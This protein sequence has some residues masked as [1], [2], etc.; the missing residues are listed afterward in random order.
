MLCAPIHLGR[1]VKRLPPTPNFHRLKFKL[2]RFQF[3][4]R[5]RNPEYE[6]VKSALTDFDLS[7]SGVHAPVDVSWCAYENSL[8][9]T[10]IGRCVDPWLASDW[11]TGAEQDWVYGDYGD[12][13]NY[14]DL[15]KYVRIN[16]RLTENGFQNDVQ[17]LQPDF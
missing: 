1:L 15:V 7:A 8:A 5:L 17:I 14:K 9:P 12:Y 6:L 13:G 4:F 3:A 2:A 11:N 10:S 16:R